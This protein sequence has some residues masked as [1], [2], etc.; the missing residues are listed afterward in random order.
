MDKIDVDDLG[1]FELGVP[2]DVWFAWGVLTLAMLVYW[3]VRCRGKC[4]LTFDV[5]F[6]GLYLYLPI[7]FMSLF[8]FSP[9]NIPATGDW[10]DRYRLRLH[11][12]FYVSLLGAVAFL[13]AAA[14][15]SRWNSA[16]PGYRLVYRSLRDFWT[17]TPGLTLLT[18]LILA[19]GAVTVATTGVTGS[20]EV[21]M[22]HTE[23]R[24]VAHLFSCFAVL[25]MYASLIAAYCWRSWK[26]AALGVLL[27][28]T[29]LGF[30]TRKVTVGTLIYF[31]AVQLINARPRRPL[32]AGCCAVAAVLGLI[33]VALG[34]ETVRQEEWTLSRFTAAPA[35]VLFG[36]NLSELRDFAWMLA[37][38][39][40]EP[41]LGTT[42]TAGLL[43][44]IPAFLLPARKEMSWGAF[45][46]TMTALEHAD[47][48][49]RFAPNRLCRGL[50]QFWPGGGGGIRAVAG[51][52]V[53]PGR[54]LRPTDH[55]A[56]RSARALLSSVVRLS[57]F[58]VL[59]SLPAI[60]QLLPVVHRAGV[61]GRGLD[62]S[63]G[64][65]PFSRP[66]RRPGGAYRAAHGAAGLN[67]DVSAGDAK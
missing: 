8:A 47:G 63:N 60:G 26:L 4:L 25:G 29:M 18:T 64:A 19:L 45:S 28:L 21:V 31:G 61:A 56:V 66:L 41:L 12:A 14:F 24:P 52:R 53:R 7:V 57:F 15:S 27:T 65:G 34:V 44:W 2:S 43:A 35:Y 37:A 46:T 9:W 16:L 50:F 39:D 23:L 33:A 22:A 1:P 48:A 13:L 49:S 32:L 10:Y 20:R 17:T 51:G 40:R 54:R 62:R 3:W 6:V 55:G 59:S 42:Y 30:G 67:K 11:E 36:N 38:W 5:F 58:R